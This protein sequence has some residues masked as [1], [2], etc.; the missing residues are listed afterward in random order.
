MVIALDTTILTYILAGT[1]FIAL[2]SFIW[3]IVL[4]R[5][6][7]RLLGG[8]H[9]PTLTAAVTELHEKADKLAATQTQ[10]NTYL[11]KA[12]KRMARSLQGIA[13]VRFNPFKNQGGGNNQSFATALIDENGDGVV[14]SSL[15]SRDRV[16]VY[17]KPIEKH[18]STYELTEEEKSAIDQASGRCKTSV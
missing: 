6:I 15:Y 8:T 9:A 14:I 16:G 1:A 5:K 4:H 7:N 13:T 18:V 3:A 17:A 10:I 2:V 12:E 11:A